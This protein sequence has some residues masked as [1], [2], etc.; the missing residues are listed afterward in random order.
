MATTRRPALRSKVDQ[1]AVARSRFPDDA[2]RQFRKN[3]IDEH[4]N[5]IRFDRRPA[6]GVL[7]AGLLRPV[8][9][10]SLRRDSGITLVSD[11]SR[12]HRVPT[13]RLRRGGDFRQAKVSFDFADPL[14]YRRQALMLVAP[15]LAQP[16]NLAH[17]L[18]VLPLQ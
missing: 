1:P 11:I 7:I 6:V 14:Q 5:Q 12:A 2:V 16:V 8:A 4:P 18:G 9:L 3:S 15:L 13:R 10:G 17:Q